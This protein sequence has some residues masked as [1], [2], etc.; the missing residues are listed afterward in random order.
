MP[1]NKE[2][3]MKEFIFVVAILCIALLAA[4]IMGFVAGIKAAHSEIV[5]E[6]QN[7]KA[8]GG[9]RHGFRKSS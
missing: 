3:D 9:S 4:S 6:M 5:H 8:K 2:G 7:D 1:K